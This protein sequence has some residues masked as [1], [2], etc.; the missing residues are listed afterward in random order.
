VSRRFLT[1]IVVVMVL[2]AVAAAVVSFQL[3][4]IAAGGLLYPTRHDSIPDRPR[5]CVERDFAGEGVTL[6]GWYC[7]G[8]GARRATIIY[9]H[10]VADNRGSGVGVI[11][12]FTPKGLDVIAY[13]SRAHGKSEGEICT[14]GFHEKA[15]LRRVIETVQS[16]P[17]IL[18]GTSLGAAVALQEAALN[19]RVTG[20]VAAEV[21]SD[22]RTVASE[23][24]PF[25]LTAGVIEKAIALAEDRGAFD[26]DQVSPEKAAESIKAPVLLI[27]GAADDETSPSHSERVL[28]AL[29]GPKRFILV[30]RAGHSQSLSDARTW[31]EIEGWVDAVLRV[32][33]R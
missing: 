13:D 23:R 15:D 10:G 26:I 2:A 1:A 11:Q 19:R 28:D 20:V 22:L 16:G 12:R 17:V 5:S 31:T 6:R 3:P 24:A 25:F 32:T 33:A 30:E 4:S 7:Q 8:E 27:H 21:F 18:V 9:L 14:Y 29:A